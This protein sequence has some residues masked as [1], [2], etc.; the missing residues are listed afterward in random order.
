MGEHNNF[1]PHGKKLKQTYY[2]TK[3]VQ[4]VYDDNRT[5]GSLSKCTEARLACTIY[6]NNFNTQCTEVVKYSTKVF[7]Q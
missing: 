1:S 7:H 5:G 2:T 4:I 3:M 6:N